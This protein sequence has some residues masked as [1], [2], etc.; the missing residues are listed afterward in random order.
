MARSSRSANKR[1][2]WS[3]AFY[4]LMVLVAG[5]M[6]AR[7]AR[8]EDQEPLKDDSNAVSGP[9]IGIDLGTTYSCVGI[10][11]NGKVEIMVNDQG[12]FVANMC[13]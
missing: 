1:S 3:I 11:K 5:L 13:S 10:M 9:V 6:L 4:L 2:T 12:K 8:A 7:T